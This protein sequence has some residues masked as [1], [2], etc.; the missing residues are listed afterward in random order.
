MEK[1]EN[2][3]QIVTQKKVCK[4]LVSHTWLLEIKNKNYDSASLV[5]DFTCDDG[6]RG[7]ESPWIASSKSSNLFHEREADSGH[8]IRLDDLGGKSVKITKI[9][10]KQGISQLLCPSLTL[11]VLDS[12]FDRTSIV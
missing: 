6:D 7:I 9:G 12:H 3:V 10:L 11:T 2:I 4:F 8:L 1:R 5:T